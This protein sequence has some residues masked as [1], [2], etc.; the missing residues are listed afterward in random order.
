MATTASGVTIP[1][2]SPTTTAATPIQDHWNNLGKSLNGRVVVPVASV[3]ARAAY[4]TALTADGYTISA[5]NPAFVFRAD[6]D[7]VEMTIDGTN[8]YASGRPERHGE[9]SGP[10]GGAADGSS[11]PG[12]QTLDATASVNPPATVA[13]STFTI[14]VAGVYAISH[15]WVSAV[16]MTGRCFLGI[17]LGGVSVARSSVIVAEDTGIVSH[18]ALRISAGG[19]V[20]FP[21]YKVVGGASGFTSRI[22]IRRIG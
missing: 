15:F 18:P 16:P 9:W 5:S 19:V 14:T 20:T 6:A 3:T 13:T 21:L 17:A 2:T 8:W 10:T 1:G 7:S 4:V 11:A 22:V 12:T